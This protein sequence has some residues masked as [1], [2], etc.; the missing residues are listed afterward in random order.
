MREKRLI[1]Q[2]GE[3]LSQR[4]ASMKYDPITS[5]EQHHLLVVQRNPSKAQESV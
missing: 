1:T 3:Q 5:T 2:T 4:L